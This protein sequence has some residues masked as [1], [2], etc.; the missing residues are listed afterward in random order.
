MVLDA[1]CGEG[2]LSLEFFRNGARCVFAVD[3]S[4]EVMKRARESAM[5]YGND[6]NLVRCDIEWLPLA[7]ETFDISACLDTLVHL[8]N[9]A[10]GMQELSRV[11]KK[12]GKIAVNM[13][14]RNPLW[15]ISIFGPS[16]I[17][18]FPKDVLLYYFPEPFVMLLSKLTRRPYLGR[19]MSRKEFVSLFTGS[20]LEAFR[21]YGLRP[22][23][24]FL[25]I[26]KKH[27]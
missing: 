20:N 15:Y 16:G 21:E 17:V 23:V 2:R 27:P 6:L 26:A 25:A 8:P 12:E 14:N 4:S 7:S 1:G 18:R 24:F 11:T 10:R 19:H 5:V 13:T 9:P 3:L 22:A